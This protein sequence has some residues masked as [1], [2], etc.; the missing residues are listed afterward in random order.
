M[1]AGI[2]AIDPQSGF[3]KVW[4]GG[5]DFD[6]FQVDNII[7]PR[8][9]GSTFKPIVYLSAMEKGIGPCDYYKNELRQYSSYKDWT[10]KNASNEYGGHYPV[11]EAL[12]QSMNTISVQVLF[13]AGVKDVVNMGYKLGID[14]KLTEVPS[15]VLGTSDVSLMDL[16]RVYATLANGGHRREIQTITK[17]ETSSGKVLYDY[18]EESADSITQDSI[19]SNRNIHLLNS[20]L[21]QVTQRGTAARLY[22]T[23]NIPYDICGKTGTTQNQSDG[24]FVGYNPDLVIGAWVGTEDRRIHFRNLGTGSGGRTALPLVGSVFEFAANNNY[25]KQHD[26]FIQYEFDC[27]VKTDEDIARENRKDDFLTSIFKKLSK[28]DKSPQIKRKGELNYSEYL[29]LKK[30]QRMDKYNKAYETWKKRF[31]DNENRRS[32]RGRN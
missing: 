21:R 5:N 1:H 14:N 6:Q 22:S 30:E 25:L 31:E 7:S 28:K 11:H 4:V 27:P 32:R 16:S 9:V 17:I 23:Y 10:P 24:W 15:I 8:Q 29:R 3:V 19:A 13:E 20:M 26:D 18:L 12:T 2:L